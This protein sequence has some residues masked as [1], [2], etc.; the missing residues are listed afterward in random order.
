M[1]VFCNFRS[2][3]LQLLLPL[4]AILMTGCGGEGKAGRGV[5]V[6]GSITLGGKPLDGASVTFM[7]GTF[8]GFGIT[9]AAGKYRLVQGALP[10]TNKIVI[11]KII[12]GPEPGVDDAAS[13]MD[14]GQMEAA[15]MGSGVEVEKPLNLVPDEYGDPSKTK[16]T[17][18]V[19]SGGADG[20]DFSI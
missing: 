16:L 13:G 17:Y 15:A 7:N 20:V 12:G 19:P 18:D 14:A 1:S 3:S 2:I 11:T 6:S 5:P 4:C 8:A 10:G 9:D